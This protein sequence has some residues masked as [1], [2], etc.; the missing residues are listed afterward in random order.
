MKYLFPVLLLCGCASV[1]P[2]PAVPITVPTTAV[3]RGTVVHAAPGDSVRLYYNPQPGQSRRMVVKAP[4]RP[5]GDFALTVKGL[6]GPMDAQLVF[7]SFFETVCVMPGDSLVVA[8]DRS[9]P[10]ESLRFS[11]RGAYANTYLT[12]A[13]R[14]FDYNPDSWPESQPLGVSPIEF[15][16]RADARLQQQLDTLAAYHTRQPLP[17]ALLHTRRQVLAVHH[18]TSLLRYAVAQNRAPT[19]S[20]PL[21]ADY[22]NFL[23]QLPLRDYYYYYYYF[24]T[25]AAFA[26]PLAHLLDAYRLARLVLPNGQL[27]TAA[28]T[29]ERLYTRVTADFG[30]TPARDHLVSRT[31]ASELTSHTSTSVAAVRAIWPTFWARTRDSTSVQELRQAWRNNTPL[32]VGSLAPAFRLS[33]ADGKAVT[34]QDFRGKVVYIDFWYSSCRP[35]LAEAPAR[36]ELKKK[37]LGR[38]VVFLYISIDQGTALWRRTIAR[39]ALDGPN[40]AHLQD[41]EGWLAARPF[42]VPSYPSYWIIGRNG[43]IRRGEAPRP[44]AGPATVLALEQALAEKP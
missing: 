8:I 25:S 39:F 10:W 18:G 12:R 22:Y 37:F 7:S 26:D 44:S 35:C 19:G 1:R 28:G 2:Q 6:A 40:S 41:P 3:L 31:L 29:A 20:A 24:T 34:L 4:V 30:D 33:N 11:G 43:R 15:R 36:Q 17:E 23:A 9:N 16:R 21:P 13:Q 5:T 32:Q 38:D 14:Q 42:Q 27:N